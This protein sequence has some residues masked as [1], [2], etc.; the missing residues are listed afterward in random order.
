MD[1]QM[2][3]HMAEVNKIFRGSDQM[4]AI[5]SQFLMSSKNWREVDHEFRLYLPNL[6]DIAPDEPNCINMDVRRYKSCLVRIGYISHADLVLVV[7]DQFDN[8]LYRD[9]SGHK[10]I[11]NLYHTVKS[12]VGT[13]R[14]AIIQR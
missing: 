7:F 2:R 11:N 9:S 8:V 12:N 6:A 1:N 14:N 13:K 10:W 4:N 3:S 5:S